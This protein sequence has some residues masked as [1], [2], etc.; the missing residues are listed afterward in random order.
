MPYI[1]NERELQNHNVHRGQRKRALNY[2]KH[3]PKAPDLITPGANP[4]YIVHNIQDTARWSMGMLQDGMDVFGED[5][6]MGDRYFVKSGT[7]SNVTS[8]PECQGKSRYIYVDN[9][10]S[11]AVPCADPN[12]PSDPKS[13]KMP[14]GLLAGVVQDIVE[15]NPFELLQSSM[16]SGSVVSNACELRRERV[17]PVIPY[18][19]SVP[20]YESRCAPKRKPLVCSLSSLKQSSCNRYTYAYSDTEERKRSGE[21]RK[22]TATG[23]PTPASSADTFSKH[24]RVKADYKNRGRYVSGVI[25]NVHTDG[26]YDVYYEDVS[27]SNADMAE[28]LKTMTSTDYTFRVI[29]VVDQ[30][31]MATNPY[32][33]HWTV[34]LHKVNRTFKKALESHY[35]NPQNLSKQAL[36]VH[37]H[38]H[39]LA[40]ALELQDRGGRR[41][42][43]LFWTNLYQIKFENLTN[44]VGRVHDFVIVKDS[45]GSSKEGHITH[46][47]HTNN[48]YSYEIKFKD[49]TESANPVFSAGIAELHYNFQVLWTACCNLDPPKPND[50]YFEGDRVQ[51]KK[52]MRFVDAKVTRSNPS[53]RTYDVVL[54]QPQPN[55]VATQS[56][57][58]SSNLRTID[59]LVI[60]GEV[61]GNSYKGFDEEPKGYYIM[62]VREPF[63]SSVSG[64]NP[65]QHL[66]RLART[67]FIPALFGTLMLCVVCK[68]LLG[69]WRSAR[70]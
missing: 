54:D 43:K 26:T 64:T 62:G 17:D 67:H 8:T 10:P 1:T 42:L 7:C 24:Q 60:S 36:D 22:D 40:R 5:M 3:V 32:Q 69:G 35:T 13:A 56:G 6:R 20:R 15:M 41:W 46:V 27:E 65:Y 44:V 57:V 37:S 12:Q 23:Q 45:G 49:G 30:K 70:S 38:K 47:H 16:G 50:E 31:K 48:V 18:Q 61:I 51:V 66:C 59:H 9:V 34:L 14:Q 19:T 53:Y 21:I 11:A 28:V 39:C 2:S 58:P 29:R 55:T 25:K 33:N 4:Y 52:G 68:L 63:V